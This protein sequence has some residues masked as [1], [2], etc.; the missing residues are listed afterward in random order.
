[1]NSFRST[2]L[3]LF[4]MA[5]LVT[6][7]FPLQAF[8]Q[9]SKFSSVYPSR[10][11]GAGGYQE[12]NY[13]QTNAV[14]WSRPQE[15][16]GISSINTNRATV[17]LSLGANFGKG[18]LQGGSISFP[19]G[20]ATSTG[21]TTVKLPVI[22]SASGLV[23]LPGGPGFTA[24]N[25]GAGW[26]YNATVNQ[27]DK[28][29]TA[30]GIG[31]MGAG[32]FSS[33]EGGASNLNKAF[34][35]LT[36]G[37]ITASPGQGAGTQVTMQ[38][39]SENTTDTGS[40]KTEYSEFGVAENNFAGFQFL[41]RA[42]S[43]NN[44]TKYDAL[45]GSGNAARSS[46][47]QV[48]ENVGVAGGPVTSGGFNGAGGTA[49]D[50]FAITN[51]APA[52]AAAPGNYYTVITSQAGEDAVGLNVTSLASPGPGY[53]DQ[54]NTAGGNDSDAITF[55]N[56][57]TI[58]AGATGNVA[59]TEMTTCTATSYDCGGVAVGS[60]RAPF[61]KTLSNGSFSAFY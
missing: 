12:N 4:G 46:T 16:T 58:A 34:I 51:A 23:Q 48:E 30:T 15:V 53:A 28:A 19:G 13:S 24:T 26:G 40:G 29:N 20:A 59:N 32:E 6:L 39:Y 45:S 54:T 61:V 56:T 22:N 11:Y 43:L 41:N 33:Q 36:S 49:G 3:K 35:T 57:N 18:T 31:V 1:M 2:S 27:V 50:A 25:A 60:K 21:L 37:G 38:I 52:P 10:S 17:T 14:P 7:A 47:Y 5:T 55:T 42:D 44:Q 9:L 8:S